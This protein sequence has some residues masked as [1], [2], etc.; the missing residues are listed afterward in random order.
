MPTANKHDNGHYAAYAERRANSSMQMLADATTGMSMWVDI[1]T[2]ED[3]SLSKTASDWKVFCANRATTT[4]D[5][6]LHYVVQRIFQATESSNYRELMRTMWGDSYLDARVIEVIGSDPETAA[7][8]AAVTP[9][10]RSIPS[11]FH[12]THKRTSIKWFTTLGK[13]KLSKAVEFHLVEFVGLVYDSQNSIQAIYIYQESMGKAD[14]APLPHQ[15]QV[16][17]T[18]DRVRVDGLLM[19]FEALELPSGGEYVIMSLALQRQPSLL[20]FGFKNPAEDLVFR[21]AKGFRA[22][23]RRVPTVLPTSSLQFADTTSWVRDQDRPA[24]SVCSRSFLALVRRRHHC[25][26]CGEVVCFQCSNLFAASTLTTK[27]DQPSSSTSDVRLCN[28]CV[29]QQQAEAGR[30]LLVGVLDAHE[31]KQWLDDELCEN[32]PDL[33]DVPTPVTRRPLPS[34]GAFT[35]TLEV[36]TLAATMNQLLD[37]GKWNPSGSAALDATSSD[38]I[39]LGTMMQQLPGSG[40]SGG[41]ASPLPHLNAATMSN[42]SPRTASSQ[43][44][45]SLDN[46]ESNHVSTIC[47]GAER[48]NF[49]TPFD[50]EDDCNNQMDHGD[51]DLRLVEPPRRPSHPPPPV[52]TLVYP[53][54]P[55][56]AR[57]SS[58]SSSTSRSH[59]KSPQPLDN[60]ALLLTSSS[61]KSMGVSPTVQ[62]P[63]LRQTSH[64]RTPSADSRPTLSVDE[65][66]TK[67]SPSSTRPLQIDPRYLPR[68][69][70]QSTPT[71]K[72]AYPLSLV[73]PPAASANVRTASAWAGVTHSTS[74]AVD[75]ALR[76]LHTRIDGPVH[77]LVVSYSDGCDAIEVMAALEH[78]APGVPFIGGLS[79]RGICDEA[80]WVSMKRGGLVALWGIHDPHGSYTVASTGYDELT[81]KHNAG[82]AAFEAHCVTPNPAFCLAYACPLVVD[83]ALAGLRRV[84]RCPV[85]GGCSVLSGQYQGY[86]QISSAGGST[87]GMAIA[88]CS[89]S[90]ETSAGWFSGYNVVHTNPKRSDVPS[91]SRAPCMGMVTASDPQNKV[92]LE[93]DHRPAAVVYREWMANVHEAGV[94]MKFPRLGYMYPLGQIVHEALPSLQVNATPVVTAVDDVAGTLTLTT[95]IRT[96]TTVA[97]MHTSTDILKDSVKRMATSVHQNPSFDI[98]DVDGC[99]M[100]LSAGVQVVLGS[101]MSMTGLVGAFKL[102]S[103]G[104]SFLGLTSFGEV[105]HLPHQ[106]TPLCDALMFSY[107]IFSTRRRL[108]YAGDRSPI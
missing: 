52:A 75:A 18:Y 74:A 72:A 50:G 15:T 33:F 43:G 26:K 60:Y 53:P 91:S 21:F 6:T 86:L 98:A 31:L 49:D 103:G 77:F 99:L 64:R 93:I 41:A 73:P 27:P 68:H 89:P 66:F 90:V 47:L 34:G 88:L 56:P 65:V 7:S 13:S 81:A 32:N 102:W 69:G 63:P 82:D 25:R 4:I 48:R 107:L 10:S 62:P 20:D 17:T 79:A 80:A 42:H 1:G 58:T 30:H 5:S 8:M 37:T 104:A 100:F 44:R 40:G 92:V 71:R 28:R 95:A 84:V 9:Q 24:C 105:G 76:D 96:G 22:G 83:D 45:L 87:I 51:R 19:K 11:V 23:L 101:S 97:L 46:N 78:G 2:K 85:L 14:N 3:V 57:T 70:S 108:S 106:P 36:N 38:S 61:S 35:G 12:K 67:P 16:S 29:V 59:Q 54:Q 94:P 55:P 39:T